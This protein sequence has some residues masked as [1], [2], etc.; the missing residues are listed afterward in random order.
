MPRT[1]PR[2]R[3]IVLAIL[4]VLIVAGLIIGWPHIHYAWTHVSTD[5]AQVNSHVTYL[6]ARIDGVATDVLVDDN[7]YVEKGQLL[8][9]VDP[10]PFELVVAQRQAKLAAAK[11]GVDQQVAAV[12]TARAELE[13]A[14]SQGHAQLASLRGSWYLL[15]TVQDLVRYEVAALQVNVATLKQQQA[16]LKFAEQENSRALIEPG[17]VVS[18]EI[19]DQRAATLAE[20][21]QQVVASQESIRQTRALLGLAPDLS[22]PGAVPPDLAQ[23]FAG[24]Q[25]ALAQT[26]Q[27]L[28]HLGR[29]AATLPAVTGQPSSWMEIKDHL[30]A[31]GEDALVEQ[32]PSVQAARARVTQ[33]LAALGGK[34]FN[35]AKPYD[36]PAVAQAQKELEEAQLQLSYAQIT[37]PIAGFVTGRSVN[38]GVHVQAGQALLA[39]RPLVEVWIDA[40]FKETQL[41]DLRIGQ[42]VDLFVDAY[43]GHIFHGR[44]AGFS[45]GTGSVMSLL[46]P[47]NATGNYVKV[48]QRLPVR[49]ELTGPN[50]A[51]WPLLAGMSV[52]PE[53]DMQAA[54]SGPNAGQ[55][56]AGAGAGEP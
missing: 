14:R 27:A 34:A 15:K 45:A 3:W 49:I 19:V 55:R 53:V 48:V 41:V 42:S 4:L 20:T 12:E 52:V 40:N 35:P 43:P 23:S 26:Q 25:Y 8:V 16:A 29:G 39:I 56:L 13:E 31:L 1:R 2:R 9:R 50:P 10:E 30:E 5:D 24:T 46:P 11:V 38:P 6:S 28:A 21:R 32:V 22:N 36:H 18:Q 51:Q 7:A 47:E 54:P 17:D 33:A 44:V 37:A